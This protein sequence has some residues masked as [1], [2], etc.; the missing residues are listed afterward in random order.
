MMK[1]HSL[2][3]LA[4]LALLT[5][6]AC[7]SA[8]AQQ[9]GVTDTEI[10][11]GDILPLTGP[12]ALLGAQQPTA[13]EKRL[14]RLV[15]ALGAGGLLRQPAVLQPLLDKT[16]DTIPFTALFNITGQPAM[17]V[18]LCW[19]AAGL[20]I[21]VQL[22][23]RFGED[24]L[25]LRL[26]AQLE[27]LTWAFQCHGLCRMRCRCPLPQ[28]GWWADARGAA[29]GRRLAYAFDTSHITHRAHGMCPQETASNGNNKAGGASLMDR[30][31]GRRQRGP[32]CRQ[33]AAGRAGAAA[34][35]GRVPAAGRLSAFHRAGG[36]HAA[37][38]GGGPGG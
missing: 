15:T 6:G 37:G 9:Q 34:A 29:C 2:T 33:A 31:D 28:A 24:G 20:P 12:P 21:G 35:A 11:L 17:S 23:G 19:N 26:A 13:A 10:V 14:M 25:L 3:R 22:A 1:K 16:F 36:R 7:A 18:P 8:Q 32:A 5:A 38:P 30:R 27:R 4:A